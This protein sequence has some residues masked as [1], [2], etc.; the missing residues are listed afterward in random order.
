M[1]AMHCTTLGDRGGL[2]VGTLWLINVQLE[3]GWHNCHRRGMDYH[4]SGSPFQPWIPRTTHMPLSTWLQQNASFSHHW[5]ASAPQLNSRF[6]RM[7][8]ISRRFCH[9]LWLLTGQ[10]K[11]QQRPDSQRNLFYW[12]SEPDGQDQNMET[13]PNLSDVHIWRT[14]SDY[15]LIMLP[16]TNLHVPPIKTFFAFV[17]EL[18]APE[19]EGFLWNGNRVGWETEQIPH[20]IV[21]TQICNFFF[22]S[23][24]WDHRLQIMS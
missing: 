4:A 10:L 5:R 12:W 17:H 18:L 16:I 14:K 22:S 13:C 2:A 1:I 7:G 3:W 19:R 20:K 6:G 8:E 11:A 24:S 15:V 21:K 9:G 23:T